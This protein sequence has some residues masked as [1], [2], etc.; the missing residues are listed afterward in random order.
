MENSYLFKKAGKRP[1][2][3]SFDHIFRG[4]LRDGAHHPR[5]I[6]KIRKFIKQRNFG[7]LSPR[8]TDKV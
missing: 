3:L 4:N 7:R 8:P 1:E 2:G 6:K 5:N